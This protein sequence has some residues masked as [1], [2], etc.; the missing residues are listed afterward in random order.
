MGTMDRQAQ[1][2]AR[3]T[4]IFDAAEQLLLEAGE[5][6]MTLDALAER[7]DLAKGTLYKHFQS[8][9]EMY[10]HLIIRNEQEMLDLMAMQPDD[11]P[12]QLVL[13]MLHHLHNPQRSVLLHQIEERLSAGSTGLNMLF[14][15]LYQI[16]KT[17]LKRIIPM[18][19]YY[20]EQIGS[21]LSARDYLAGIWALTSGGSAILNSSYYQRYLGHRDSLRRTL[22]EQALAL[23]QG[24]Q[25]Y[26]SHAEELLSE[27]DLGDSLPDDLT[28]GESDTDGLDHGGLDDSELDHG[29]LAQSASRQRARS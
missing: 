11:L 5:S 3:E 4:M 26:A 24:R 7:L 21:I 10:M 28:N 2:R 17:R 23:P 27:H 19:T 25:G 16:R 22:I 13:F 18:V 20:L 15:Q 14:A 1:F 8:K 12:S 9:D 29:E 6:G